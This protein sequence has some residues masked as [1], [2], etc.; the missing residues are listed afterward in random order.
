MKRVWWTL[1]I[2]GVALPFNL[3]GQDRVTP[4][5]KEEDIR[6]LD[7]LFLTEME[8]LGVNLDR[9]AARDRL[10]ALMHDG[11]ETDFLT[12]GL[13]IHDWLR[14]ANDAHMR[15]DF[16]EVSRAR[17]QDAPPSCSALLDERGPWSGFSPGKGVPAM[18]RAAWLER[19]WAWV[20]ALAEGSE[21]GVQP[22]DGPLNL[23]GG[24]VDPAALAVDGGPNWNG[25]MV[26]EHCGDHMVWSVRSFGE[27]SN[28]QFARAFRRCLRS[29]RKAGLPIVLDLSG[30]MGGYRSRRH[31]VLSAFALAEYWPEEQERVFGSPESPFERVPGMPFV[32]VRHPLDSP[33]AVVIDG[34]SF[35]ASL[36]LVD[37]LLEMGRARVFGCAPLGFPGGCS[38]SPV[39]QSLPGSGWV[40]HVP[41]RV[42][43]L[44]ISDRAIADIHYGLDRNGACVCLDGARLKAVQWLVEFEKEP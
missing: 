35:S 37:A 21:I 28:R 18:A 8:S 3:T 43:R 4:A 11:V 33:L 25:G 32:R 2:V 27:G 13:A 5:Q 26:L 40:V 23:T 10:M 12:W 7:G 19:T 9:L 39:A 41:T 34:L 22:L 44:L 16:A 14:S 6:Y 24:A 30:N 38:G 31:A 1:L 42:T 20:G 29:L 15:V 17:R 36:L